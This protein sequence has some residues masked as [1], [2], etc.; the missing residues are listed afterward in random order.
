MKEVPPSE[1]KSK[2][3]RKLI[4][5]EIDEKLKL[6]KST[7]GGFRSKYAQHLLKRKEELLKK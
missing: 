1:E 6:V 3:I 5:E 7:M 2:K 4:I